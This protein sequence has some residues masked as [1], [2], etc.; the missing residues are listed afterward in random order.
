MSIR[1]DYL[2]F[3]ELLKKG[4]FR[5]PKYQRAY[6]WESKQRKALFLD[7]EKLNK[8]SDNDKHHFM[9]TIVCLNIGKLESEDEVTEFTEF[10][11]V[12]GQQRVTTLIIL[13]KSIHKILEKGDKTEKKVA[14]DIQTLLIKKDDRLVLLQ[15]NH[16]YS[17]FF[18]TYLE[19]GIIP[20]RDKIK[21]T[22]TQ[23]LVEAF[24]ECEAF[25]N[26]WSKKNGVRTGVLNLP[27]KGQSFFH[28]NFV[29]PIS[30]VAIH[31]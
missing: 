30:S 19:K 8:G 26:E 9:A 31:I 17:H 12:D 20:D 6:S 21:T 5:I 4:L 1:P 18:R 22:S 24:K 28:P 29:P 7:L 25:V 23:R 16:D 15:T 13:L 3:D 14:T 10:H 27:E 11:I 2:T